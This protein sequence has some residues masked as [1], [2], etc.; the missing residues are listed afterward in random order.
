MTSSTVARRKVSTA[1]R[2]ATTVSLMLTLV[3][4]RWIT[5]MTTSHTPMTMRTNEA[6]MDVIAG[7]ATA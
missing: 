6:T 3:S 4:M 1:V 5:D 2:I 7:T